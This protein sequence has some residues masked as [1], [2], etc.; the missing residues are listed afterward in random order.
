MVDRHQLDYD[1]DSGSGTY[2]QKKRDAESPTS[3]QAQGD[4]GETTFEPTD[5]SSDKRKRFAQLKKRHHEH[6]QT[7]GKD[8]TD[9]NIA[10]DTRLVCNRLEVSSVQENRIIKL[11]EEHRTDGNYRYEANIMAVATYVLN[12][13]GRWV[14]RQ[15]SPHADPL[16]DVYHDLLDGF[17]IEMQTVRKLRNDI[18][19]AENDEPTR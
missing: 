6:F 13:D 8:V 7:S 9:T 3:E 11:V 1:A 19:D 2:E 14:Q 12:Q 16:N 17:N 18:V 4:V 10:Y 15:V 5:A